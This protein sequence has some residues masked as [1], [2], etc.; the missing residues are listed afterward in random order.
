M[1]YSLH[2]VQLMC[3]VVV[4][5]AISGCSGKQADL[6][7]RNG[8]V[9]TVDADMSLAEAVA[10]AGD[11]VLAVGTNQEIDGYVGSNTRIIDLEGKVLI[12]GFIDSHYHFI[13][14]GKR[15][16]HL[17]LDGTQS[18]QTFLDK[19]AQ[20]VAET[21]EGEWIT[22][23]GW[24]EEDWPSK[25]FP[26][27]W[28]LDKVAPKH[29]VMLTRADGHAIVV[30]SRA[31][32]IAGITEETANPQG[33]EILHD[34]RGRVNGLLLD[35][36]MSIVSQHV[37]SDT[38]FEKV[39]QYAGMA[40]QV[41]CAYGVT[42]VHDMGTDFHTI[43]IY[44]KLYEQDQLNVRMYA[45]IRG[46]SEDSERLLQKGPEIGL[47]GDK[48]TVRGIKISQDGALGSRGAALLEPY[49]DADTDGLLIYKDEE[50]Y[51]TIKT[52]LEN[53]IQMA[54][55]AIGDRANRNVL[56]LFERAFEAAP[57]SERAVPAPRFRIEHAQIVHLDDIPRFQE[58]G[59]IPSMQPS[60]AIGD[61][62]FAVR[63]LG[64]DRMAEA[65]AWRKFIDQGNFIP[66]GS[67][68]PV[69]EGNPMIEYY[70]AVV[71]KDTTGFSAAGWYPE[72]RMTRAEALKSLTIWGAKA[73]FMEDQ[74]GSIE[75]GKYADLVVLDRDLMTEPEARLFDIKV[76]KT[77]IGGELV[78]ERDAKIS[79]RH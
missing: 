1:K 2:V 7:L 76:L 78:F 19:V 22:G 3:S 64:Q 39:S 16:Y 17:D 69:E 75:P 34:D 11:K 35:K 21:P 53:G 4:I 61:L 6:V 67:D 15:E 68:A 36:A 8:V 44:K 37:P 52:A 58:L 49:S 46:P 33:G 65:Y 77:F 32:Q 50:I 28:D 31:L 41:A 14:V 73:A 60:H 25:Q 57:E 18:L 29:P 74:I 62:H 23:R 38:T 54:I 10:I 27:R 72:Y 12:P 24:I 66:G 9:Y 48:L 79:L 45:Y 51:P 63:R 26:T 20:R 13:G 40:D 43:N 71:R 30:N 55:H 5:M 47:Y 70:A 59:V 56:D 42:Q